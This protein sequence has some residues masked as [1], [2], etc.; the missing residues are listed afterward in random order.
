[1]GWPAAGRRR[2]PVVRV[3]SLRQLRR[4]RPIGGRRGLARC[5]R[6]APTRPG[7]RAGQSRRRAPIIG[8]GRCR[9]D[10][11]G[12]GELPEQRSRQGQATRLFCSMLEHARMARDGAGWRGMARAND[13][14]GSGGGGCTTKAL[15]GR[16]SAGS[17]RSRACKQRPA[18]NGTW[19]LSKVAL[20]MPVGPS[21]RCQTKLLGH[22]AWRSLVSYVRGA[23]RRVCAWWMPGSRRRSRI[24]P[25]SVA[26]PR[27]GSSSAVCPGT[28][29][30]PHL[31]SPS[32][33]P[34]VSAGCPTRAFCRVSAL[35]AARYGCAPSSVWHAPIARIWSRR[36]ISS[37]VMALV[38]GDFQHEMWDGALAQ[39][40]VSSLGIQGVPVVFADGQLLHVGKQIWQRWSTC[41][42][43][44]SVHLAQHSAGRA[45]GNPA[46]GTV[47]RRTPG[48]TP[49]VCAI[50]SAIGG[51]RGIRTP[52]TIS[53]KP[54]FE[55]GAFGHSAIS[56][57]PGGGL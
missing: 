19:S 9:G 52:V 40:E 22:A 57:E 41:S 36:S 55:T 3:R 24:S 50:A 7:R 27:P 35:C 1:M 14:Q 42:K 54:V 2:G 29:S 47:K 30:S 17:S 43:S 31:S 6:P 13:M 26:A 51:E 34:T 23:P 56:P 21:W 20:T 25:W 5:R 44:A 28:T 37:P 48:F 53:G 38:H 49:G 33:T 16:K 11:D 45:V 32:S 15:I 8:G 12:D 4:I 46:H 18:P 10:G 39:D